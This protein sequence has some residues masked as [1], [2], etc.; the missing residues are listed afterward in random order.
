[1]TPAKPLSPTR[2]WVRAL[3]LVLALNVIFAAIA[4]AVALIPQD[5]FRERAR[6]AFAAGDFDHRDFLPLDSRRG[7]NQWS[8]C[9]LL[10][11]LS[12]NDD[13]TLAKAFGPLI[14][15]ALIDDETQSCST[16]LALL[17]GDRLTDAHVSYRYGRF[18]HGYGV[19]TAI[20][21]PFLEVDQ[22]RVLLKVLVYSSILS[23]AL[24][25]LTAQPLTGFALSIAATAAFFWALPYYGQSFGAAP[26]DAFMM[27]VL[28]GCLLWHRQLGRLP[29]FIPFCAALGALVYYLEFW[30]GLTPTLVGLFLPMAYLIASLRPENQ[31]HPQG[32]WRFALA[33]I[34][35]FALG[36]VATVV[37]KLSLAFAFSDP[38]VLEAFV[39]R[40]QAYS[41]APATTD[42]ETAPGLLALFERVLRR[43]KVLTYGSPFGAVLLYTVSIL[44]WL[45]AAGVAFWRGGIRPISDFLAFVA[46]AAVI[47]LWM[48]MFQNHTW[49][50]A[51]FMARTL[52]VPTALGFGALLWQLGFILEARA[53]QHSASPDPVALGQGAPPM[54]PA[55]ESSA[56][57]Q[58]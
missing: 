30:T 9:I 23:L 56:A 19:T 35:A 11:M 44:A 31:V 6:H 52:I 58:S 33:G 29:T 45:T 13:S 17:N 7:F 49:I 21:L 27:L 42:E 38:L 28:A 48:V 36:G 37:L 57:R 53:S 5:L 18:W 8:D 46:G 54:S 22:V 1:M 16:L 14:H 51:D 25:A 34:A 4:V 40:L 2:I 50:H 32:A 20:L 10:Q 43:G 26:G 24:V 15:H 41:S 39:E 47:G 3:A 12:S 55:K